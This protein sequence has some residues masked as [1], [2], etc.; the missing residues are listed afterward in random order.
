MALADGSGGG[1]MKQTKWMSS[2]FVLERGQILSVVLNR[3]RFEEFVNITLR[4]FRGQNHCE[5]VVFDVW[6]FDDGTISEIRN[7]GKR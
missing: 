4:E 6:V 1:H 7:I 5:F 2:G 3:Q